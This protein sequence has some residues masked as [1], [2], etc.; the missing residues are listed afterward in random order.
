MK[1]FSILVLIIFANI[2]LSAQTPDTNRAVPPNSNPNAKTIQVIP[3]NSHNDS[4]K[5]STANP[6]G[7]IQ[8]GVSTAPNA[9][10]KN[11]IK[12]EPNSVTP[13]TDLPSNGT[14]QSTN[15]PAQNGNWQS[16][17]AQNGTVIP[18]SAS[19]NAVVAP[20][21]T[22]Q[23]GSVNQPVPGNTVAP[24]GAIIQNNPNGT[25]TP[26]QTGTVIPNSNNVVTP[27]GKIQNN[28]TNPNATIISAP[29]NTN[30]T[31][32]KTNIP[33]QNDS[34]RYGLGNP[35]RDTI[36]MKNTKKTNKL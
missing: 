28:T 35:P 2:T 20:N 17:P 11:T 16:A 18:N 24:N 1:P 34:V 23:N 25:V 12:R 13:V 15:P 5:S 8:N 29:E 33:T 4:W 36:R 10:Q 21:G 6:N 3:D 26:G 32:E 7:L 19:Q 31:L 22:I 30:G 27:N 9:P 14:V